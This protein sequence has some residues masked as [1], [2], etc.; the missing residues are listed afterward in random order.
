MV[1]RMDYWGKGCLSISKVPACSHLLCY[2]HS[3]SMWSTTLSSA[4]PKH[5]LQDSCGPELSLGLTKMELGWLDSLGHQDRRVL[6]PHHLVYPR[7][8]V[9]RQD[10]A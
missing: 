10:C 5:S 7:S 2:E 6:Y 8:T 3:L 4:G 1:L 9:T